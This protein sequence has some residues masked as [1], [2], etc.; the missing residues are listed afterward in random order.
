M[1]ADLI[2]VED[3]SRPN[4]VKASLGSTSQ[5]TIKKIVTGVAVIFGIFLLLY[6][7]GQ[8]TNEQT[9]EVKKT[10]AQIKGKVMETPPIQETEP[11]PENNSGEMDLRKKKVR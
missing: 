5:I 7:A 4:R 6:W 8:I 10:S 9:S 3:S 1:D 2:P 11:V